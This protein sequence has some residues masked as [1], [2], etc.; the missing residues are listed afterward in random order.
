MQWASVGT[1]IA[2]E[3]A[4]AP[5]IGYLLDRW[6]GWFPWLTFLFMAVGFWLGVMQLIDASK[7]ASAG[8]GPRGGMR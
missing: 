4:G 7:K 5:L 6:L 2:M 3:M 1:T 8:G